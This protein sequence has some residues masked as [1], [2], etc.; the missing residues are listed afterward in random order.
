MTTADFTAELAPN[1]KIAVPAE[2]AS[3]VPPGQVVRVIL[4]WGLSQDEADWRT[5]GRRQFEAS[6]VEDDSI[7]ETLLDSSSTP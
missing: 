6:W 2:V 7:Y 4:T 5:A 1:G 3:Q